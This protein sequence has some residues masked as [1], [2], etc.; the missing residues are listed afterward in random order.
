MMFSSV[1]RGTECGRETR[2]SKGGFAPMC[3]AELKI[4]KFVKPAVLIVATKLAALNPL[5]L[6]IKFVRKRFSNFNICS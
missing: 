5:R 1:C 4:A 6:L 2:P 3:T